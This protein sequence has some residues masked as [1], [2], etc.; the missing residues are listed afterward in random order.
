M[1]DGLAISLPYFFYLFVAQ[2]RQPAGLTHL[3][4]LDFVQQGGKNAR[5]AE[6]ANEM[7]AVVSAHDRKTADVVLNHFDY[8]PP[9]RKPQRPEQ[10]SAASKQQAKFPVCCR[11]V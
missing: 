11:S 6:I 8:G 1:R 7:M 9:P 4:F 2:V 3:I 5:A 10:K